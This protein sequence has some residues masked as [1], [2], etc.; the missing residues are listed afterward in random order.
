MPKQPEIVLKRQ[1]SQQT[2]YKNICVH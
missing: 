1:Q 2:T